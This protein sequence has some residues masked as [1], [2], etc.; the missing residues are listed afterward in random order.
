MFLIEYDYFTLTSVVSHKNDY[1]QIY[2][3]N[4]SEKVIF[5]NIL[6]IGTYLLQI[7]TTVIAN[8][9]SS[10]YYKLGQILQT[11]AGITNRCRY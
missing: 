1:C 5:E 3:I 10:F 8:R 2:L 11:G 7:R 9:N 6:Q 4:F